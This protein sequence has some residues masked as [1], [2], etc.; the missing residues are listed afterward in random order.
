MR[1]RS[2]FNNF[3]KGEKQQEE[4]GSCL[5]LSALQT[6]RSVAEIEDPDFRRWEGASDALATIPGWKEMQRPRAPNPHKRSRKISKFPESAAAG[7]PINGALRRAIPVPVPVPAPR[8]S[9]APGQEGGAAAGLRLPLQ[10][11]PGRLPGGHPAVVRLPPRRRSRFLVALLHGRV[12][13]V[14]RGGLRV[15]IVS[16]R[17]LA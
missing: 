2:S 15:L 7:S 11:L 9:A 8:P 4:T 17:C 10:R 12:G 14:R 13:S 5:D 3:T 16:L 1:N 6:A